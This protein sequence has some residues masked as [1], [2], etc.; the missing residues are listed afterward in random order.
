LSIRSDLARQR[1]RIHRI[2]IRETEENM[3]L[4]TRLRDFA[5]ERVRARSRLRTYMLIRSLPVALQKDIGWPD[6][7]SARHFASKADRR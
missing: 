6:G 7:V 3:S 4:I 5:A 2:A 1:I